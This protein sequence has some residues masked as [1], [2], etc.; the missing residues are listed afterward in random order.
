MNCINENMKIPLKRALNLLINDNYFTFDNK[1]YIKNNGTP[2][3]LQSVP[4]Y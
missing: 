4:L 2:I 1:K 3:R